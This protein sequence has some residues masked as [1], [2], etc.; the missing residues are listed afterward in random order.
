M[1]RELH[2]S[3]LSYDYS[4]YGCSSGALSVANTLAD[5][6]AA[7]EWLLAN[8][9]QPSD[10]ILYGAPACEAG[11]CVPCS[12]ATWE[13]KRSSTALR[14]HTLVARQQGREAIV[15]AYTASQPRAAKSVP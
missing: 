14:L 8:G 5:I 11:A 1:S 15:H 4:G 9:R 12:V 7:Y 3:I 10:V 2:I 6:D 13:E